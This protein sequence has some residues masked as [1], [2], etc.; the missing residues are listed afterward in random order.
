[1]IDTHQYF[2]PS[3][4]H[5]RHVIKNIPKSLALRIIWVCS[6]DAYFEKHAAKL[7]EYLIQRHCKPRI[8]NSTTDAV[9][10]L[11]RKNFLTPSPPSTNNA[12]PF[13]TN[14]CPQI[15]Y[16]TSIFA[17]LDNLISSEPHLKKVFSE[18]PV[19]AYRRCPTL[20]DT[21]VTSSLKSLTP[22]NKPS[23]FYHCHRR[24][25]TTCKHSEESTT[26]YSYQEQTYRNIRGHVN[27][28]A[29]N[30]VY[31]I[32]CKKCLKQYVGE[33]GRKLKTRITEHMGYIRRNKD[34]AIGLHFNSL[35][36][37]ILNFQVNVVEKLYNSISYRKVKEPF[38]INKLQAITHGLNKKDH[39]YF[40]TLSYI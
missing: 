37:Y 20:R 1:M 35:G 33:T 9:R 18:R 25:C 29:S 3:S 40:S 26:L 27:C 32:S 14:F 38:W 36:D 28:N 19:V 10:L 11:P 15:P 12:I 8:L 34:T 16:F 6:T 2:L 30:V 17:K 13:V 31:L 22:D 4:C 23:G 21:L 7:R 39:R 5:P 24:N